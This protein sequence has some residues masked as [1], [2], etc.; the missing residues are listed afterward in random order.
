MTPIKKITQSELGAIVAD[1]HRLLPG[2]QQ[3]GAD[4]VARADGPLMHCVGFECLRGGDYRPM[5]FVR[6]LVTPEP[7]AGFFHQIPQSWPLTLLPRQHEEYYRRMF[8]NMKHEFRPSI[9]EGF[10]ALKMLDLCDEDAVPKSSQAYALAAL[11]AYVGREDR[12]RYWC[13]RFPKLVDG[14]A[15]PWQPLDHQQK[16]FL[17][18]LVG[19]L[20]TGEAKVRLQEILKDRRKKEGF[21]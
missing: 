19:W 4:A 8:E 10:D 9:T 13:S 5:N 6:A 14:V 17:D 21:H 11:N 3:I 7:A 12:A 16:A 15:Y 2:W 1:Y 18:L 20:D